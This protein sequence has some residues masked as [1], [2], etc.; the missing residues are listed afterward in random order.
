MDIQRKL[1]AWQH[2]SGGWQTDGKT[3]LTPD[4]VANL[5]TTVLSTLALLP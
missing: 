2:P 4:G 1:I 3:D 5:E